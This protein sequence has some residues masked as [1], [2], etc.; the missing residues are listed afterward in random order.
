MALCVSVVIDDIINKIDKQYDYAVPDNFI[1]ILKA[2][3]RVI[4]PFSKGNI[5][6]KALVLALNER[7]D[8]SSLKQ[9]IDVF[10]T[11]VLM[12][13]MQMSL[14]HLLK[15]RYFVTYYGALKA[16][17]PRGVDFKIKEY[18][19]CSPELAQYSDRLAALFKKK[20]NRLKSDDVPQEL[21][22]FFN[23]GKASGLIVKDIS[24][25]DNIGTLTEK[26]L[27]L[28]VETAEA[29][30]IISELDTRFSKQ[31][32]LLS[33]F[34]DYSEISEKDAL[35]YSGCGS[36]TVKTL[37]K[38]GI[39]STVYKP[40]ERNPYM[41]IKRCVDTSPLSLTDEQN[42]AYSAI[43]NEIDSF[44]VH[45]IHGVT[46][47]G[48]TILYMSLIDKVISCGQ[49]AIFM[50]PEISLTPQTLER[51]YTRYG[52]MVAVVHSGLAP[53][54]R[55]DEWRKIKHSAKSVVVG[56]RSA[57]F[58]PVNNLGIIIIDEEHEQSYKSESSPRYHARD[59]A[60]FIC[61]KS[62]IPL[63]LG[64]ATPS[65]ESR[66]RAKKN[67]YKYYRLNK[68]FNNNPLPHAEI[69]DMRTSFKEGNQSFL[70]EELRSAIDENLKREE[71]TILFL[72]RRGAY[73][74]VGCRSCGYVA[75][76][77][78]CGIALTYHSANDRCMCHYCGYSIR[79]FDTCPKCSGKHIK[80]LGIGTQLVNTELEDFFPNAE[81][82]RM[83]YDTVSSYVSYGNKLNEF[84]NGKYNIMLGTQMV[85]K[86]LDFPNVT[87]VGVI[88]ADLS[89]Y[90]DDF[91]ANERTFSLLTQVCGRSGRAG[92]EGKA[93]IQTYSPDYEVI[94]YAKEQNYDKYY[95]F[96][97][98][99][100]KAMNYPPFCDLVQFTVS[101]TSENISY[102]D[103]QLLYKLVDKLS[104]TEFNDIP[105]RML[106]PTAPKIARCNGKYRYNLVIKSKVCNRLY[107]MLKKITNYFEENISSA[108]SV[109]VNPINNI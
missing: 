59:I 82:L 45:L 43:C 70:S 98:A 63:V 102:G 71:Q 50:I 21:K 81:I 27:I 7:T 60:K 13:P 49:S 75:K 68:R 58:A 14:I 3:M 32:D 105:V 62:N 29:E 86:G 92:K 53:G 95:D 97:I 65:V 61:K 23:K 80:K 18:Y 54:E 41:D 8:V 90:V 33:V 39:I 10:D 78:N 19:K 40:I 107:E 56:T 25:S 64:S 31:R 74:M 1:G 100:R 37:E 84:K 30:R 101:N 93:L 79:M 77:E 52:D 83:D 94:R 4:V 106:Y 9:V 91:R 42:K 26:R 85:A 11:E 12:N 5:N 96:E 34:L 22:V 6:K 16:I 24:A 89:L 28:N 20:R 36:S 66:Y 38:K 99:F 2:G 88:N 48:K 44:G 69:I 104:R 67:L 109:N 47:C 17:V 103:V 72:N 35:Y 51:F 87:L 76:C 15:S 57:V 108:L 46:G 55:A 73:T